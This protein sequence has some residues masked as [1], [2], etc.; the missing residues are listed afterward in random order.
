LDFY[1]LIFVIALLTPGQAATADPSAVTAP[2]ATTDPSAVIAP[3]ATTDPAAISA[4][5]ANKRAI[6]ASAGTAALPAPPSNQAAASSGSSS[7]FLIRQPPPEPPVDHQKNKTLSMS[8]IRLG[9]LIQVAAMKPLRLDAKYDEPISLEQALNYTM[10]NSLPIRIAHESVVFQEA[11]LASQIADF[12]PSFSLAYT[13]TKSHVLPSTHSTSKVFVP[14]MSFPVFAGGTDLYSML[15]QYYRAKGWSQTYKANVNDALLDVYQ[16][17]TNLVLN[18]ALLKIRV[19]AVEVSTAQLQLNE[20]QYK[21]GTGTVFAIMQSRTQLAA[22]K[23]ALLAQQIATRQTGL[24]LGYAL[25]L[26]LAINLVPD[27][28]YLTETSIVNEKISIDQLLNAA[29]N[30]RPELRQFEYFRYAAQRNVQLA[31]AN[32]YP[33]ASFS[34]TYN[35]S[36]TQ[37]NQSNNS[38][39]NSGSNSEA[40]AGIFGGT[41]KTQQNAFGLGYSL[42]N[43]GLNS[44]ANIVG[45]RALSRQSLLQANQELMLIDQ[46]VRSAYIV[47]LSAREQIDNAAYG[48]DSG[49]E[50]LRLAKLRLETGYGTNLELLQAQRDY[51]NALYN[52]A[53]AIVASNLAQAQLLHD[54]GEITVRSLLQ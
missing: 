12:L 48:V 54:T 4:P 24:L 32:L 25:D 9:A 29:I 6:A 14:R 43:M 40:G 52:Q 53:Q 22:D 42:P 1:N 47:A 20:S 34:T 11:Q 38:N 19:K 31:A 46:Q 26:P 5:S 30:H 28:E 18:H 37:I 23:Q 41:F 51:I 45:A 8:P 16:K 15:V 21:A 33:T 50:A 3:T 2:A 49:A 35:Q 27:R 36:T 7:D 13:F 44:V 17:Y 39:S 10:Q